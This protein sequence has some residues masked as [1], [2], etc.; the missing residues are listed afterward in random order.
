MTISKDNVKNYSGYVI[1]ASKYDDTSSIVDLLTTDD[2]IITLYCK[3]ALKPT[4]KNRSLL[5]VF[6]LVNVDVKTMKSGNFNVAC[7]S[8]LLKVTERHAN[9][10]YNLFIMVIRHLFTVL[11]DETFLKFKDLYFIDNGFDREINIYWIL[12]YFLKHAYE[13]LSISSAQ[14][15][16]SDVQ[17]TLM[18]LIKLSDNDINLG[19]VVLKKYEIILLFNNL[20]DYYDIF[21]R[22]ALNLFLENI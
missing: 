8:K 19:K 18:K 12:I 20:Y 21:N 15:K 13:N 22:E 3:S 4:S 17:E 11:K 6:N 2:Q 14:G 7:G 5:T 1:R 16:D 9:L 10:E